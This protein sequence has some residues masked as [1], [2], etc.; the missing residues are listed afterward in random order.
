LSKFLKRISLC[1][2]AFSLVTICAAQQKPTAAAQPKPKPPERAPMR[3]TAAHLAGVNIPRSAACPVKMNFSGTIT[4][5][6]PGEVKYT[7]AS[8]DGGTWPEGTLKF[9]K[10]GSEKVGRQLEM[11]AAGETVHGWLQVKVLSPNAVVSNKAG[12]S[13][14]CTAPLRR[15]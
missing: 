9:T 15:K 1:V 4:A 5:N 7:W 2:V 13:V 14:K 3:V 8:S 11:G 12:Y 10:A 6:G